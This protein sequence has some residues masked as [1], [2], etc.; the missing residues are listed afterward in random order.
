LPTLLW[1]GLTWYPAF[2]VIF[3]SSTDRIQP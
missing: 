2:S 1:E 3:D